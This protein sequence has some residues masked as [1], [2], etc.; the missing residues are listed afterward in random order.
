LGRIF[1]VG[2]PI[3]GVQG[4]ATYGWAGTDYFG[5]LI[6]LES[7]PIGEVFIPLLGKLVFLPANPDA[8][9]PEI[10][11]AHFVFEH[12]FSNEASPLYG[13]FLVRRHTRREVFLHGV[14]GPTNPPSLSLSEANP[15]ATSASYKDSSSLSFGG[16]NLWREIGTWSALPEATTGTIETLSDLHVWLGLRNSDDQG[17]RFDLRAELYKNDE[18]V[19]SRLMRCVAGL[20][21]NAAELAVSFDSF[22]P[23]TF[24]GSTD[25][26][27]LRLLTRI[28]TNPNDT[29]CP[30]HSSATGLR[31]Y[32][33]G[34]NQAP[35]FEAT[36]P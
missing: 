8:G 36:I 33:G 24:D 1:D 23:A 5:N 12:P 19:A 16:G 13:S 28:G 26:L 35:R 2:G 31:V 34:L 14:G 7:H 11:E 20:T 30:G 25:V 32:F 10:G 17:T 18:L 15:T 21:R 9:I 6:T 27:R 4:Y 3:N 22:T 29:K